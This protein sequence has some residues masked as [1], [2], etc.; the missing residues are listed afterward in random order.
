GGIGC[1]YMATWMPDRPP[2]TLP[3]MGGEG[4]T[5]AGQAPFTDTPPAFQNL[6]DG[7]YVHSGIVAIRQATSAGANLTSK[8]LHDYAGA[9]TGAQPIDGQLPVERLI[10]QLRGEGIERIA[11]VSDDPAALKA[12]VDV[13]GGITLD[14]RR[15]MDAIQEELRNRRG[16]TVL[17]YVQ[18]CAAEK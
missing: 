6:G 10:E 18:T 16:T 3:Q 2:R 12:K 15:R 4:A 7:T 5:W 13:G 1:H 8:L 11:V 9:M 14:H 17:L